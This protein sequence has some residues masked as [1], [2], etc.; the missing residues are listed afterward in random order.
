MRSFHHINKGICLLL[1]EE[2]KGRVEVSCGVVVSET[3]ACRV[4]TL[5]GSPEPTLRANAQNSE[6]YPGYAHPYLA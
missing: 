6:K 3:S 2:K 5:S 4:P 1:N